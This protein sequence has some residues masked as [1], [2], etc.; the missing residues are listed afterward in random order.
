MGIAIA[1]RRN[2]GP[3]F[4]PAHDAVIDEE[5]PLDPPVSM[6]PAPRTA[7]AD[8][9][10]PVD[11]VP[12][13]DSTSAFDSAEETLAGA[14]RMAFSRAASTPAHTQPVPIAFA[15]SI[16]R[17]DHARGTAAF[18]DDGPGTRERSAGWRDFAEFMRAPA[19]H[20]AGD[21][22]FPIPQTAPASAISSAKT[23]CIVPAIA[24]GDDLRRLSVIQ[25]LHME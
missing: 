8:R 19:S 5:M 4:S 14:G 7:L 25:A 22:F 20:E 1:K 6:F 9:A 18:N 24:P 2:P 12:V 21:F 15:G 3:A 13:V 16:A 23:P 10:P 11:P 17:Y